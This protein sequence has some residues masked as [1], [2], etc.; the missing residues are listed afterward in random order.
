LS[1]IAQLAPDLM[2]GEGTTLR[3]WLDQVPLEKLFAVPRLYFIYIGALYLDGMVE[4]STDVY[5][6]ADARLQSLDWDQDSAERQE[7]QAG[8]DLLVAMRAY[9]EKD[10]ATFLTYSR[11]YLTLR[12][13]GDFLVGLG[14]GP[15]GRHL[16]WE[17]LI[18]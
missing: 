2:Q 5:W 18:T 6:Q 17:T 11:R 15:D 13:A 1:L 14:I 12:P 7:W 4:K 16:M 8:L 9:I 3:H 10:F